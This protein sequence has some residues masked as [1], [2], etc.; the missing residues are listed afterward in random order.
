[1]AINP[2]NTVEVDTPNRNSFDLSHEKKLS[3]K[4][5]NLTPVLCQEVIPGDVFNIR[6]EMFTRFAPLVFPTMHEINATLHFFYVPNRILWKNWG[7]F[8]AGENYQPLQLTKK[9]DVTKLQVEKGKLL[10]YLGLP[11]TTNMQDI[12][13]FPILAYYRIF[14]DY[15]QDQ[16]NDPNFTTLRD[17]LETVR[18]TMNGNIQF[19]NAQMINIIGSGSERFKLK[20]RAYEHDYF[21]SAL[22]F[23]QK[24]TPVNIPIEISQVLSTVQVFTS[25]DFIT[26]LHNS[27]D[28]TANAGGSILTGGIQSYL[29]GLGT[30]FN[31]DI[32]LSGTINQLR[33]AYALQGFLEKNARSGTRYQELMLAHYGEDIKDYRISKPEYI[34]GLKNRIQINE[35]TST[36]QTTEAILG[37]YAG[38]ASGYITGDDINYHCPE[39]GVIIG[40]M[41]VLPKTAYQQGLHK[42]WS[43]PTYLDY[44][45]PEFAHL[46]EQ[47]IKNS[48]VY[49]DSVDGL[50]NDTFGYIPRYSE[51]KYSNSQV[52]GDFRDQL[53]D[54]H[55]GRIFA[56]RPVLNSQFIYC[57]PVDQNRIFAVTS[58]IDNLYCHIFFNIQAQRKIPF[59]TNPSII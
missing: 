39:H 4:M 21:T 38:H 6:P 50:N 43:K 32:T 34:G 17:A 44:Y 25:H 10:D 53:K 54:Y 59:F 42:L 2:F 1:M 19:T 29:E 37:D 40:I 31:N 46:G 18:D 27:G 28:I 33:Q 22:P 15:Y 57:N 47:A 16:N 41:S 12:N 56:N 20:Q 48:E 30:S 49:Y 23:A 36:A 58:D 24:G 3:L 7:K 51:L 35:V 26:K 11:I 52:C 45:F 14:N 8:I 55:L 9:D 13:L 5:G